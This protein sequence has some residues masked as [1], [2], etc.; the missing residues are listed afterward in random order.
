[1]GEAELDLRQAVIDSPAIELRLFVLM[2]EQRLIVPKGVDVELRGLLVMGETHLDVT[3][4]P[5]RP[6]T[7]RLQVHVAGAMGEVRITDH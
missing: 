2:G 4:Q 3:P 1:M 5:A 6:G 7:P